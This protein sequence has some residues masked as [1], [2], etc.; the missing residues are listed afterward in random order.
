[1]RGERIQIP[2]K[3]GRHRPASETPFD[4]FGSSREH[5]CENSLNFRGIA[6]GLYRGWRGGG[7]GLCLPWIRVCIRIVPLCMSVEFLCLSVY[8]SVCLSKSLYMYMPVCLHVSF[9]PSLPLSLSL[10]LSLSICGVDLASSIPG[11]SIF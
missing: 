1:M 8:Q 5:K 9:S 7:G 6:M 4:G 10:S 11:N 3:A 2:Q